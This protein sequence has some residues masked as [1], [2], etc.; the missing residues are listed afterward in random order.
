[1]K[2]VITILSIVVFVTIAGIVASFGGGDVEGTV[3]SATVLAVSA[4]LAVL[5][6]WSA[7]K[8]L[9]GYVKGENND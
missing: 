7:I 1:M 4:A 6:G 8:T 2:A 9:V 5:F 3:E